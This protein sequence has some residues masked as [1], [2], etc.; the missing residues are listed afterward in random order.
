VASKLSLEVVPFCKPKLRTHKCI[1]EG[2][3]RDG[4]QEKSVA[5]LKTVKAAWLKQPQ[6]MD[7]S[8]VRRLFNIAE[9]AV[10]GLPLQK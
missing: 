2:R 1:K 5:A 9:R 10:K 8:S 6:G 7:L 4:P 3:K